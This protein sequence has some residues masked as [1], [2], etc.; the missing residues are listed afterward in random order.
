M[1]R[2]YHPDG[3][4][5][6]CKG[7]GRSGIVQMCP[8]LGSCSMDDMASARIP[9]Q[10]QWYQL[11]VNPDRSLNERIV[12]RAEQLGFKALVFTVDVAVL[13]KRERNQRHKARASGGDLDTSQRVS[14]ALSSFVSP[15]LNWNM[16]RWL[17]SSTNMPIIL[18]GIQTGEDAVLAARS[19]IVS[20]IMVSNH[21]GRRPT[22]DCLVEVM[23]SQEISTCM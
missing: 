22:V 8:T 18:K 20:G 3:E 14:R 12:R 13:G 6:L 19:G 17:K 1:G 23:E 21:G 15:S 16:V 7:A 5:E 9:G 4:V 2:L 10:V 11:H